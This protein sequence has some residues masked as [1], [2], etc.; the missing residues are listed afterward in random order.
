IIGAL[1]IV[2]LTGSATMARLKPNY[3]GDN[4]Y[5]RS[6]GNL[7]FFFSVILVIAIVYLAINR[8]AWLAQIIQP[9]QVRLDY[10]TQGTRDATDDFNSNTVVES[11]VI[12]QG[13]DETEKDHTESVKELRKRVWDLD[14]HDHTSGQR[15][16]SNIQQNRQD[17]RSNN[18]I[19]YFIQMEAFGNDLY[20]DEYAM[21]LRERYTQVQMV[22]VEGDLTPSKVGFGPFDTEAEAIRFRNVHA[23][24][25]EVIEFWRQ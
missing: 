11:S 7:G 6:G 19:F 18:T 22:V 4:S 14:E 12:Q 16:K 10:P 13:Q 9:E 8:E 5:E 24:G 17:I 1:V 21:T 23:P 2:I 3:G 25:K 20:A 15:S